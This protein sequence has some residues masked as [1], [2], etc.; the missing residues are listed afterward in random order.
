VHGDGDADEVRAGGDF[1]REGF[2]GKVYGVRGEARLGEVGEGRG[3]GEGLV[4]EFVEGEEEEGGGMIDHG[5]MA[6]IKWIAG[7]FVNR[8]GLWG[9]R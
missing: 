3:E 8:A 9:S 7:F 4:A 6:S 1:G 5:M 2:D